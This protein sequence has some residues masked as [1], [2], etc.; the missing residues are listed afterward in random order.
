MHSRSDTGA[1]FL[2]P[3]IQNEGGDAY[4]SETHGKTVGKGQETR[5]QR[6]LQLRVRELPTFGYQPK[7][8]LRRRRGV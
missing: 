8:L 6:M 1:A 3:E 2:L 7:A 4:G 5:P